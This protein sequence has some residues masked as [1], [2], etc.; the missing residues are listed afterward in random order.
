MAA[1]MRKSIQPIQRSKYEE[2]RNE[3]REITNGV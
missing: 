1:L 2:E 3:E